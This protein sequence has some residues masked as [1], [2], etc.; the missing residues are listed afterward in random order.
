MSD[1]VAEIKVQPFRMPNFLKIEG[2]E[3]MLP[4]ATMSDEQA[5]KFWDS[6]LK[7]W[8]DHVRARR[9]SAATPEGGERD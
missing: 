2:I 5:G 1:Y 7:H 4:V 3:G 6:M 9:E 8:L